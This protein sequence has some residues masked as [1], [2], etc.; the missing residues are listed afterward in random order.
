MTE[1]EEIS[2]DILN[3]AFMNRGRFCQTLLDERQILETAIKHVLPFVLID[4][5]SL[6]QDALFRVERR[7]DQYNK[8]D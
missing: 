8:G 2:S 1:D 4:A 3:N 7:R 6:L 5:K